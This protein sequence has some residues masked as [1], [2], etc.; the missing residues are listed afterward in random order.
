MAQR[1]GSTDLPNTAATSHHGT[2]AD[3]ES[4]TKAA[5]QQGAS[6]LDQ[7][8]IA[9]IQET[10]SALDAIS[11][12]RTSDALAAIERATGKANILLARNP[13]T[14]LIPVDQAVEVI[15]TAPHDLVQIADIAAAANG[16]MVIDDYPAA[17]ALLHGLMSEIRVRTFNLP[18]ATYPAA[19]TEAARRLEEKKN[20]EAEAILTMA[21]NTLVL[22]DQVTPIPLLITREA[23]EQ[24]LTVRDKD[25]ESALKLLQA[26]KFELVRAAALGYA[27]Q[28]PEYKVL[29]DNISELEKQLKGK[30]DTTSLFA[31]LRER[32]TAFLKRQSQQERSDRPESQK[33]QTGSERRAA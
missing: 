25:T 24:A 16:A 27:G 32:L 6:V 20:P 17:R 30:G 21:L 11:A 12:N 1:T 2:N 31:K 23:V 4:Q 22:V 7:D 19:L 13:S 10:W 29:Q 28:D 9:A 18:L 33:P 26:A 5:E 8:A 14:A 3:V 15:D